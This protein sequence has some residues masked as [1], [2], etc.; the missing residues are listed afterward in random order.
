MGDFNAQ[1]G[2]KQCNEEY[3]LGNFGYEKKS[4]N[5]QRLVKFYHNLTL[6]N[7]IFKKN[8]NNKWTWISPGGN[9]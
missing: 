7:S 5:G 4:K 2:I 8:K 3:V 9:H 6:L 1:V